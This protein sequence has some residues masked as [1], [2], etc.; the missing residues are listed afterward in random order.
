LGGCSTADPFVALG[1]GTCAFGNW[2]PPGMAITAPV[3]PNLSVAAPAPTSANVCT[4]SDPFAGLPGIVSRCIGNDWV[5]FGTVKTEG[6]VMS[7]QR[8]DGSRDWGIA[9][10]GRF[11][12][13]A[14][15]LQS[16][17]QREGLTFGSSVVELL[18]VV[19]VR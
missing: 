13:I 14:G 2:F 11:L 16:D 10:A 9:T 15:G 5:P 4:T 19:V 17:F 8:P 7:F 3:S 18:A 1:G 12:E 6:A